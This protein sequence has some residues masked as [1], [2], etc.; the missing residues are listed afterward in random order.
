MDGKKEKPPIYRV[1]TLICCETQIV[2][3][4]PRLVKKTT[5][6]PHNEVK[7]YDEDH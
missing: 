5:V 3:R 6:Y 4:S 1:G 2:M 7:R